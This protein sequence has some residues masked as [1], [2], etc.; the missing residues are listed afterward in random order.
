M[1]LKELT[2]YLE[3]LSPLHYAEDFDN[4]GLLTGHP[5]MEITGVLVTLDTLESV[6]DEAIAK[7][8]NV[9]VSFH[10]I[11]F[12]GLKSLTRK[13]YVERTVIKAIQN[14]IAIYAIHTALDNQKWG[15]SGTMANVL[16][17]ENIQTLIPQSQII[18]KLTTYVPQAQAETVRQSLF[19]AGAGHIGN[20]SQCS[21]NTS[22][23]GTYL[24]NKQ[25]NP[26][27]GE[28][29]K[30]QEESETEIGVYYEKHRENKVLKALFSSHPYEEVAYEVK[31]LDN[32]HQ[33]IGLGVYGELPHEMTET[34]FLKWVKKTFHTTNIRHSI[35]MN[36]KIKKVAMI[37]GSGS[38][39]VQ[40]AIGVG[41]DA[42]ISADFK[43]HD[44]FGA[45]NRI[46]ITD[47]GHYESEQFTKKLLVEIIQKKFTNFAVI[48]AETKTN[49]VYN[50][51]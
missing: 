30:L 34:D 3:S 37:G 40:K 31:T 44:F 16:G 45:E 1:V 18:K 17:L 28:I 14:N 5:E 19:Q 4:V 32:T 11:I 23:I 41:A 39:G 20:Y 26:S 21:F 47:I 10:P 42:F 48:L 36:K 24:P 7:K 49:P 51:H 38:F 12:K 6:V 46:L 15:V 8:C 33:D 50:Y 2:T 35:L 43:Y 22:G 13:N 29:G 9:I 25:A 27:V